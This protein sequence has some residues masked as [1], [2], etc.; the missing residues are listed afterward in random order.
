MAYLLTYIHAV[1]ANK[2]IDSMAKKTGMSDLS[3]W[4]FR[5]Q[6]SRQLENLSLFDKAGWLCSSE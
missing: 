4:I 6:N 3:L 2:T 1:S 5:R